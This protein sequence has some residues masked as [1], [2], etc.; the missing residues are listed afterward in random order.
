MEELILKIG[1]MLDQKLEEK[2]NEKLRDFEERLEIKQ[3]QKLDEKIQTLEERLETKLEKKF[4]EKFQVSEQRL[5]TKLEK[6]FDK[7]LE[8][9]KKEVLDQYFLFEQNYGTKIDAILDAVS[10]ELDKNLK[11]SEKIRKIDS[12]MDRSE[13]AIFSLEK[14]VSTLEL[15]SSK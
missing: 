10:L 1:K 4:D 14:R 3:E 5:E 2:F 6:K 7:K 13:V 11:K 12:R 15:N 8:E 9:L